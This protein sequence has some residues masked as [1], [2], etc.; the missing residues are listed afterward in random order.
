MHAHSPSLPPRRWIWIAATWT[1][2]GLI[3]ATQNV[4][5][6]RSE[7]MHH[8]WVKLFITLTLQWLPWA[9]ATPLVIELGRRHP[10]SAKP[11]TWLTH[12]CAAAGIAAIAAAWLALLELLLQPWLPMEA[13]SSFLEILRYKLYSNSLASLILYCFI[14]AIGFALDSRGR[15][16]MQQA[17]AARLN[18]Q[19]SIAHLS[20]LRQQIEP[21]FIF[22]ALN[23]VVA[24]VRENRKEAAVNMIVALSDFLRRVAKDFKDQQV[25][26]GQ[27][28]EFL[29]KYLDIQKA[30]YAERLRVSLQVPDTLRN[31]RVPSLILQPLVENAIKH[32]IEKRALGGAVNIA[33]ASADDRLELTV[34]NEGPVLDEKLLAW[35]GQHLGGIGLSNLR[36][37]LTLLYGSDFVL[38]LKNH[39]AGVQVSVSLPYREGG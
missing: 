17:E 18:E 29:E 8:A 7:G 19:L 23:A 13:A 15:L 33:A 26:L 1:G 32:G 20:A 39:G 22:N 6:M 4:F 35:Q 11:S 3:D 34:Y 24:L 36:T 10:P 27:E 38:S 2:V 28:V 21:H 9:L 16:A 31:A 14:L 30:R 5:A 12:L 25:P 37:R